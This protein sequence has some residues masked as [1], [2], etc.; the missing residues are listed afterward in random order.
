MGV[1]SVP[2]PGT[3]TWRDSSQA[4]APWL[5]PV[6]ALPSAAVRHGQSCLGTLCFP[7]RSALDPALLP[8]ETRSGSCFTFPLRSGLDP[9]LLSHVIK[10]G[11]PCHSPPHPFLVLITSISH[12][13]GM[14]L[15][16]PCA[17]SSRTTPWRT[18]DSSCS[19]QRAPEPQQPQGLKC[20][21]E[22]QSPLT[23]HHLLLG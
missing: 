21:G 11:S 9:A 8:H 2:V 1:R 15:V 17:H 18:P 20:P 14:D 4:A 3:G 13:L 6:P 19:S 12:P 16:F 22:I 7:A 10:S 5:P 23:S